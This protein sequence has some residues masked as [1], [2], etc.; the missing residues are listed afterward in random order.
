MEKGRQ[1][2][3]KL[4]E[5]RVKYAEYTQNYTENFLT[6]LPVCLATP[7]SSF[8]SLPASPLLQL[9]CELN[10]NEAHAAAKYENERRESEK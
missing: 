5:A 7:T 8:A 2:G 1:E 4:C 3:A 9:H 6:V 10:C